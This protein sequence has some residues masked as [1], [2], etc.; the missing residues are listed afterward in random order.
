MVWGKPWGDRL[1]RD[2]VFKGSVADILSRPLEPSVGSSLWALPGL[3]VGD[4]RGQRCSPRQAEEWPR[5]LSTEGRDLGLFT[6]GLALIES[7][8]LSI[9]IVDY[10]RVFV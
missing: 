4:W 5:L 8:W 2:Q 3:G 7:L 10:G 9:V 6:L 1:G